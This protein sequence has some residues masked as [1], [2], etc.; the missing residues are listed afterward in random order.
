MAQSAGNI[1]FGGD[2]ALYMVLTPWKP[3]QTGFSGVLR[4]RKISSQTP[5]NLD[6]MGLSPYT[7][8]V[9]E[10]G[11]DFGPPRGAIVRSAVA[12]ME[13]DF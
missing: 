5:Q 6:A 1:D 4:V 12:G 13:E 10:N 9:P 2:C 8:A 11:H 3:F 7:S